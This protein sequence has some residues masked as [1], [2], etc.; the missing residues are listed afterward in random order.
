MLVHD[1]TKFGVPA[2]EFVL[3]FEGFCLATFSVI[4]YEVNTFD[5]TSYS[6]MEAAAMAKAT[7]NQ[8]EQVQVAGCYL[9]QWGPWS[10]KSIS[11]AQRIEQ[12]EAQLSSRDQQ[13]L[14]LA[15]PVF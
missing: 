1:V 8:L 7:K 11:S 9:C 12:L 13:L 2:N 3:T 10:L 4:G 15:N 5:L 6:D 14:V